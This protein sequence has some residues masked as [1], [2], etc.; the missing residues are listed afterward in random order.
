MKSPLNSDLPERSLVQHSKP[1]L[2]GVVVIA[3]IC[4]SL[5]FYETFSWSQ[6]QHHAGA[7][8]AYVE[9]RPVTGLVLFMLFYCCICA[10]PM[11]LISLFTL[12]AG[13][14]F[15]NVIG[16]LVVS[17]MSALGGSLLFLA[18]R[19]VFR[20]WVQGMV[21]QHSLYARLNGRCDSFSA[22]ISL[23]LI[24]G[25]PFFIPSVVLGLTRIR[26]WKFY[27]STQIG[28]FVIL[29]VYV[30]AGRSLAQI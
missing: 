25:L 6:L 26:L 30:N 27:L 2:L 22:A 5:V 1:I 3:L 12:L 7:I 8:L 14:L 13:Y 4:L 17:F 23:R 18:V 11:P 19:Y 21:E 15:G 20:D 28:L 24:P 29:F 9:Q 10:L 16:F